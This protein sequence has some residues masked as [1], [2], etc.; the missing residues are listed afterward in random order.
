VLLL[1]GEERGGGRML[2]ERERE[3]EHRT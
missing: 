1:A 3:R 2:A